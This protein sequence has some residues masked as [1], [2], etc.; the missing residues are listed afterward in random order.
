MLGFIILLLASLA[1]L[2][3]GLFVLLNN[4]GKT[5]N[6]LFFILCLSLIGWT[7]AN[8][9]SLFFSD[10]WQ[11]FIAVN[12]LLF[13]V[14]IQNTT[15]LEF[16]RSLLNKRSGLFSKS[17]NSIYLLFSAITAFLAADHLFFDGYRIDDSGTIN[18][19]PSSFITVFM[20][21]AVY[22][23][24]ASLWVIARSYKSSWSARRRQLR[25][26]LIS[27]GI[28]FIV[29]PITNFVGPLFLN[30]QEF[31]KLSPIYVF[32]F[33]LLIAY[34]IFRQNLFNVRFIVARS[35]AYTGLLASVAVLYAIVSTVLT[36]FLDYLGQGDTVE[37][38][39]N[40]LLIFILALSFQPLK[41]FF[42]RTTNRI[43]FRDSYDTQKVLD[44]L[45]SMLA[46]EIDLKVIVEGSSEIID[47][48][49]RPSFIRFA[50]FK[51]GDTFM[52]YRVGKSI[53]QSIHR[54]MLADIT[55]VVA[56]GDNV[57]GKARQFLKDFDA[58]IVLKLRTNEETVGA[59]LLGQKQSGTVYSKQDIDLLTISEKELAI[60][61]QNAR[62]FE[63]IQEFNVKLQEE[64]KE[65]TSELRASNTK[66]KELDEAKDEFISMASHQLRTP[67][68][69]VKGYISMV[70][71]GDS[72][73]IK[74]EQKKL[75]EEAFMSSQRMVYLIAD[76][77]NVSRLKT[78]KF[79]IEPAEVN[80]A[81]LVEQEASQLKATARS[82]KLKL[83]FDKPARFPK[84]WLDETKI[85]QV[86]M[87]FLDN[88]I[89]YTP[90]GGEINL[91]L[92]AKKDTI[93]FK[94]QDNGIGVPKEEQA[95]LFAKF[96]RAGNAK[97]AR[98]DGTGLGLYMAQRVVSA[99][100]GSIIFDSKVGKGSTFGFSFPFRSVKTKQALLGHTQEESDRPELSE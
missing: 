22:S 45:S 96:Y 8:Q 50:V 94:V 38:T 47:S 91:I 7:T 73:K 33:A 80:L 63:Q 12:W 87:N 75:L 40:I 76:L 54:P 16:T 6:R 55:D 5:L 64:I 26:L 90:A 42:N 41:D 85:R 97:Q 79:V 67:L 34:S 68:T 51:D 2:I 77:L 31:I 59:I 58:Q 78:G 71:E 99:Q 32:V 28:I 39:T 88:A 69:S 19:I 11:V 72:G 46:V 89:Y 29:V 65:A 43:F 36:S 48:A 25:T 20:A 23:I 74:P 61:V 81:D 52:D 24:I 83:K 49:L 70:M 37:L 44:S 95:K 60:A 30:S 56:T 18:L 84:V 27:A 13:F 35:V 21:H 100:G 93:E 15:F 17:A 53:R 57:K 4:P 1:N 98:P 10:D 86:V 9:L 92:M 14:V 3:V 66:L 62:Y 82:R